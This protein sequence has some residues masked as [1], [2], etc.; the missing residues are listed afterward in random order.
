MVQKYLHDLGAWNTPYG[1]A[2]GVGD[3]TDQALQRGTRPTMSNHPTHTSRSTPLPTTMARSSRYCGTTCHSARSAPEAFGTYY[4]AYSIDSGRHRGDAGAN[5]CR[6]AARNY[7]RIL[8]FSTAVAGTL[9]TSS[10][11]RPPREP[12]TADR[13]LPR[14]VGEPV[15]A[16]ALRW[17]G[18]RDAQTNRWASVGCAA[19]AAVTRLRHTRVHPANTGSATQRGRPGAAKVSL[20]AGQGT[21][22]GGAGRARPSGSR[23][24]TRPGPRR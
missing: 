10:Y 11:R 9:F 15:S 6:R 2:A 24:Y 1:R 14:T 20:S 8:D 7:D 3:R 21:F 12:T 4:I 16:E 5:V 22:G 13:V 18:S 17:C 23:G 19:L